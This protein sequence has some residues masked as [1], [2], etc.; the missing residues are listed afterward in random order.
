MHGAYGGEGQQCMVHMVG[1]GSSA[2]CI[3]GGGAAVHGAYGGEG[4]QCMVHMG[5]V[6]GEGYMGK[7]VCVCEGGVRVYIGRR[8]YVCSG[9]R[10]WCGG[11]SVRVHVRAQAEP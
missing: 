2:W 7:S 9:G 6:G 5:A 11:A 8:V 4:Q 3:W 10:R 1:R